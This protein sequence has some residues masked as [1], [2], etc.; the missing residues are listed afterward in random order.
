MNNRP[1]WLSD[2]LS[3][4]PW[5]MSTFDFLY[6]IFRKDFIDSRPRYDS[7]EIFYFPE[8]EDGKLK[9]FWHLTH[10]E[11]NYQKE[12]I[13]DFRRSERLH[14]A[15]LMFDNIS[16]NSIL[17]WD[18]IEGDGSVKTYIWLEHHD[19][20]IV[21]KKTKTGRRLIT[22]FYIEYKNKR[23]DLYRKYENRSSS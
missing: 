8:K 7:I 15:R 14:W 12:R 2:L 11:D 9:I 20:L 3:I 21:L 16:D 22:A 13:P 10:K 6:Q 17:A 4:S 18:Y 5:S 23:K 19:Y 1:S